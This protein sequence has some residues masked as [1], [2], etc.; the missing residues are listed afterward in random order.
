MCQNGFTVMSLAYDTGRVISGRDL[1]ETLDI[2][3]A[4]EQRSYIDRGRGRDRIHGKPASQ[5]LGQYW[6]RVPSI[7]LQFE[8]E[9]VESHWMTWFRFMDV[10]ELIRY[11]FVKRRVFYES[12]GEIWVGPHRVGA[13]YVRDVYAPHGDLLD[14][15][16]DA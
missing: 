9:D 16:K 10:L 11:C 7:G 5:Y 15:E 6:N 4:A 1:N 3:R 2:I 13:F 8:V 12:V 14:D